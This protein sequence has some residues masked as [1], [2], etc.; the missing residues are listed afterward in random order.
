MNNNCIQTQDE[1]AF[2]P[3]W[4]V[5]TGPAL[6]FNPHSNTQEPLSHHP[7]QEQQQLQQEPCVTSASGL[8][9]IPIGQS[10]AMY[11]WVLLASGSSSNPALTAS[12]R[13]SASAAS[14][15]YGCAEAS[16][17]GCRNLEGGGSQEDMGS[18]GLQKMITETK[19]QVCTI[20]KQ[21][22]AALMLF[23]H[24]LLSI[25]SLCI[26][27]NHENPCILISALGLPRTVGN[28]L[29]RSQCL[30]RTPININC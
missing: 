3:L 19:K 11:D 26:T 22:E 29:Q 20:Y 18:G 21:A 14:E 23:F 4:V 8:P 6:L 16:K 5:A 17:G 30:N 25:N 10:K 2:K 7:H 13:R 15:G 27:P 24:S 28:R 1:S 12:S 9:A